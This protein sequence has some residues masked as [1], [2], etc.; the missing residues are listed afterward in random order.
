MK[1]R[2]F[3]SLCL[4][5]SFILLGIT[6]IILYIMPSGRVAFWAN[7]AMLGLDKHQWGA[8]HTNLGYLFLVASLIHIVLNWSL[9]V[10]Y[11]KNK[12]REAVTINAN[13]VSSVLVVLLFAIFT[14]AEAPPVSWIQS[15]GEGLKENSEVKY[16]SPPY[17]HAEL[18]PLELFCTRTQTELSGAMQQLSQ[19]GINVT[20]PDQTIADIAASNAITPQAVAMVIAPQQT[21][22]AR[23]QGFGTGKRMGHM[24]LSEISE[25]TGIPLTELRQRLDEAGYANDAEKTLKE[26]AAAKGSHPSQLVMMLGL[27][28]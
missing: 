10:R 28:E 23:T 22:V 2:K 1:I 20:G 27:E 21:T 5:W 11:L 19:A 15:F 14:I 6:S 24:T 16:G 9:I 7:W 8:L 17:G 25:T 13:S 12:T 26:I 18:P 4:V 3:T